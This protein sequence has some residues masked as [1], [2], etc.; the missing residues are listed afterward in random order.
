MLEMAQGDGLLTA[1][2]IEEAMI[3]GSA[4]RMGSDA[5]AQAMGRFDD[6]ADFVLGELLVESSLMLE[7]TP[8]VPAHRPV[9]FVDAV[10]NSRG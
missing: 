8:P 4:M 3:A 9:T 1:A 2:Q 5:A 6:R 7:S 10:A